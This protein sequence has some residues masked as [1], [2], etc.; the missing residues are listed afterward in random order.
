MKEIK[1]SL[2]DIWKK[3]W[4]IFS[5]LLLGS[6]AI[7]IILSLFRFGRIFGFLTVFPFVS[8]MIA[9]QTGLNI[10]LSKIIGTVITLI[11]LS[12]IVLTISSDPKKRKTGFVCYICS[13]LVYCLLMFMVSKDYNFSADG[14][15]IKCVAATPYDYEEVSCGY[16]VHPVYG[17]KVVP[18]TAEIAMSNAI[19]KNG[20]PEIH[21]ITPDKNMNFFAP[22]GTPL[23]YYYQYEDGRLEFFNSPGHHPQLNVLLIPA[24][25]EVVKLLFS[26]IDQGKY[27][28]VVANSGENIN[29]ASGQSDN[30]LLEL[31]NYLKRMQPRK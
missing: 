22:D 6:L 28:M 26:Y 21:R 12:S 7:I 3:K 31:S 25:P 29:A 19:K 13:Y 16:K 23:L 10:W 2:N 30:P 27:A 9:N 4:A 17:T 14:K 8:E 20:M 18:F 15:P 1:Q 11:S 24:N 5:L